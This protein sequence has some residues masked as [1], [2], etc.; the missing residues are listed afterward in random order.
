M[1]LA[2]LTVGTPSSPSNSKWD[3]WF[4]PVNTYT[5]AKLP[6]PD[7]F[8]PASKD[9]RS[10]DG[11]QTDKVK[12]YF[13]GWNTNNNATWDEIRAGDTF[14]DVLRIPNVINGTAFMV[15]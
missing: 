14:F 1:F 11:Y 12:I 4:D 3:F 8:I 9:G 15:R 7:G 6:P 13:E 5:A 10:V 2:K